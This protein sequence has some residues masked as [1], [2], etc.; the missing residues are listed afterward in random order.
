MGQYIGETSSGGEYP[1]TRA[2]TPQ[3][4][5]STLFHVLGIDPS[6]TI[7]DHSGR[8]QYLLDDRDPVKELV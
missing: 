3:N 8:P 5:L 1:I 6:T 4:I 2:Y 7:P